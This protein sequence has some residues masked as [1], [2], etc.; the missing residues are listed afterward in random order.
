MTTAQARIFAK[1]FERLLDWHA[2]A[3]HWKIAID[4]YPTR[5]ALADLDKAKMN[6]RRLA[7]IA[8]ASLT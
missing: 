5:G 3:A 4:S 1:D 6:V 8:T 7:C 2:A